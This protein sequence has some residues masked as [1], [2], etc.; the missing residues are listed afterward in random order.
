MAF[1]KATLDSLEA[2]GYVAWSGDFYSGFTV[3][4]TANENDTFDSSG[5]GN[6]V[7]WGYGGDDLLI[8]GF[9]YDEIRGGDGNDY[10]GVSGGGWVYGDAGNDFVYGR[11]VD[12]NV[13]Y[14]GLNGG[15]GNDELLGTEGHQS[16]TMELFGGAGND[17]L[18]VTDTTFG[19]DYR[20]AGTDVAYRPAFVAMQ[21]GQGDDY[22]ESEWSADMTGGVG[23]DLFHL[24][25][26]SATTRHNI[27]DFK[28]GVDKIAYDQ[29]FGSLSVRQLGAD[30]VIRDRSNNVLAQL[31]NVQASSITL[32]DFVRQGTTYLH[33]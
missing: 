7:L 15:D 28:D 6:D 21:G 14:F 24:S 22:L 9:G 2:S 31:S 20:G 25:R 16:L 8:S 4:S 10:V 32:A 18:L 12:P 19:A 23:S 29:A 30:T 1:F 17:R 5:Y 3:Q 27:M 26:S 11:G 13:Y 33:G